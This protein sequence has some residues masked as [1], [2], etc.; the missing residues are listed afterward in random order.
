MSAPSKTSSNG[1]DLLIKA[2]RKPG[3]RRVQSIRAWINREAHGKAY[4]SHVSI[5]GKTHTLRTETTIR[6]A[7]LTFNLIH[8]S[9][10]LALRNNPQAEAQMESQTDFIHLLKKP[11]KTDPS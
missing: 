5:F 6:E 10:R 7:A 3:K 1:N 11:K 4:L 2:S 8:A 9:E